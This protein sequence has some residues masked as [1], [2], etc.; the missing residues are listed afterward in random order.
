MFPEKKL[1][2]KGN[3]LLRP[4]YMKTQQKNIFRH[5]SL[6]LHPSFNPFNS[7][8]VHSA[9]MKISVTDSV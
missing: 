9:L 5:G 7:Q 4:L 8:F 6:S 3:I 1:F 2:V